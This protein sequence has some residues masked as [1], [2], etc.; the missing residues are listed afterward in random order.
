MRDG[1]EGPGSDL[2]LSQAKTTLKAMADSSTHSVLLLAE[3]LNTFFVT[4]LYILHSCLHALLH[5]TKVLTYI[6]PLDNH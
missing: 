4:F 5:C 2:P 1:S 3:K 6:Q